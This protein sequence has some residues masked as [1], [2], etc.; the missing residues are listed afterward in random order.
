MLNHRVNIEG[1]SVFCR[2]GADRNNKI[3]LNGL[4]EFESI[5]MLKKPK[6]LE[7]SYSIKSKC[8]SSCHSFSQDSFLIDF[9]KT[10]CSQAGRLGQKQIET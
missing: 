2:L 10:L 5:Y 7:S 9:M 8:G 1:P 4:C 3:G 6:Y